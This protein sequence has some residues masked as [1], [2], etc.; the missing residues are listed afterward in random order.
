[1]ATDLGMRL[2]TSCFSS[3]GFVVAI[4]L[5]Q[6]GPTSGQYQLPASIR[7]NSEQL[8]HMYIYLALSTGIEVLNS[9]L[10]ERFWFAPR[11][12]NIF[13]WNSHWHESWGA[14]LNIVAVCCVLVGN[15][16]SASIVLE[17]NA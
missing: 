6:Y 10:L 15:V 1:M 7:N 13:V 2:T 11:K 9:S 4:L 17:R 14:F 5:I 8:H 12:L 16:M 3:I